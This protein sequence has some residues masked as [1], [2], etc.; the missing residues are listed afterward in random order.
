MELHVNTLCSMSEDKVWKD[1]GKI[2]RDFWVL[3]QRRK[4][5]CLMKQELKL[6]SAFSYKTYVRE[7]KVLFFFVVALPLIHSPFGSPD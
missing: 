3:G 2:I 7:R 1:R 5:E 6:R 4:S